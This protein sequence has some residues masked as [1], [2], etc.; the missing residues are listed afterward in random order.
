[1]EDENR[2]VATHDDHS[3]KVNSDDCNCDE[4]IN[5]DGRQVG[6]WQSRYE[7]KAL[8]QIRREG[9]L[10]A[11]Y[12]LCSAG[13]LY[14]NSRGLL[15]AWLGYNSHDNVDIITYLFYY[16]SAG[17]LGGTTYG[18]KYFY[19]VIA[20]GRWSRDRRA[21]RVFSPWIALVI[22]FIMGCMSV[23]GIF[24][25]WSEMLSGWAITVGF[26]AGYFADRFVGVLVKFADSIFGKDDTSKKEKS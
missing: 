7:D 3:G 25:S 15:T 24:F 22:G 16:A 20:H 10:I 12:M 2:N 8:K 6:Q 26:V 4:E 19:R 17:M 21:W 1:M 5:T 9:V 13:L 11:I 14:A 18:M 23:S